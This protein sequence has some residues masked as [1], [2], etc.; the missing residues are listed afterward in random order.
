MSLIG[1]ALAFVQTVGLWGYEGGTFTPT[2]GDPMVVVDNYATFLNVII[3]LTA[4]ITVLVSINYLRKANLDRAEYYYLMLFSVSGMMLMGMAND[5]ILVFL[6]LELLSIPLYVLSGFAS[7]RVDSEESA[8][9]YF[10]LG[11]FASGFFVFGIAFIYGATG[12]TSLPAIVGLIGDAGQLALAG[13]VLIL[14]GL[15]FKVAAVPFHMWTPD[16]YEGAPTSVTAFMSVGA[17]VAGFAALMRIFLYALPEISDAWAP[18]IATIAALTL[19][20]GNVAALAQRNVKRM[21]AYSSIAHAGFILIGVA[22][23]GATG[24]T[25]GLS[26]ALFYM[27]AYLFTNLGAFAVVLVVE[28]SEGQGVMIDDYKGLARR[29]PYLA[30]VFAYFMLSLTGI[31]PSGGFTAK[32]SVFGA[33][34]DA[35]LVWLVIAGV[36]TSIVSAYFYLRP[37]FYAFMFDGEGEVSVRPATTIALAITAAATIILGVYP[38]PV[39]DLAREAVFSTSTLIAGG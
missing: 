12:T 11:A 5:L 38:G 14:V 15:C 36:L 22:A 31:P 9:K 1:I 3:L 35:G 6:A 23:S 2:G 24:S 28:R 20:V 18:A 16:V 37:V 10:L 13:A 32:F 39:L 17:K 26:A 25:V 21:L 29:K 33:A 7:P 34:V 4:F 30:L 19:L 8:M 27:M